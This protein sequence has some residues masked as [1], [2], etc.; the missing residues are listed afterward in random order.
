MKNV[1]IVG[2]LLLVLGLLSFIV[3]VP[4]TENHGVKI[5]DTKM[6]VQTQSSDKLPPAVGI[7]LLAGGVLALVLGSRKTQ[8][9]PFDFCRVKSNAGQPCGMPLRFKSRISM[10]GN[11]SE[12]VLNLLK[13]LSMLKELDSDYEVGTKVE[14]ERDAHRLRQQRHHEIGKEIRALAEQKKNG[15]Q[16]SPSV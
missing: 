16:Q 6:G 8:Y 2:V 11:E 3:P 10:S 4:H 14:S 15:A 7:V 5:G 9:S 12:R 13:V 1:G